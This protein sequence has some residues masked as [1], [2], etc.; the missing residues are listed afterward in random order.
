[1]RTVLFPVMSD[2]MLTTEEAAAVLGVTSSRV[3]QMVRSGSLP[4][5][6]FGKAHLIRRGDLHLVEDRPTAGRP[7]KTTN[8]S[9]RP[10]KSEKAA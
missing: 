7:P 2:E 5:S 4:A 3:R 6:R 1:M 9:S 8:K 10:A